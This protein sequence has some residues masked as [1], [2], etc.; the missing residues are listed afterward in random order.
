ML[1]FSLAT[2]PHKSS[3]TDLASSHR[4]PPPTPCS[5]SYEKSIPRSR[6]H[7]HPHPPPAKPASCAPPTNHPSPTVHPSSS[8][9]NPDAPHSN[10]PPA[11]AAPL[12][13]PA[14]RHTVSNHRKLARRSISAL[15]TKHPS[16][17]DLHSSAIAN[18]HTPAASASRSAPLTQTARENSP[19][20]L[21]GTHPPS[22]RAAAPYPQAP[23]CESPHQIAPS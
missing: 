13:T 20:T 16:N 4:E 7:L 23:H 2:A 18:S 12:Q 9:P 10:K 8:P 6:E 11:I 5:S 19:R 15:S 1:A 3:Q 14:A 17:L 22:P 21:A